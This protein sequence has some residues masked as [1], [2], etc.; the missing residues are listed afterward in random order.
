MPLPKDPLKLQLWRERQRISQT[1]RVQPESQIRKRQE[2]R[3]LNHPKILTPCANCGERT[4]HIPSRRKDHNYCSTRCQV[5]FEYETGTRDPYKITRKA[6]E[7]TRQL[8]KE[9]KHPLCSLENHIKARRELGRRHY[10]RT[11]LEERIGWALTQL[12]IEFEKQYPVKH[13]IDSLGRN[14]YYFVD[15]IVTGSNV[16]IEC[17]GKAWHKDE[18]KDNLRQS[19]IENLGWRFIRFSEDEI[20]ENVMGCAHKIKDLASSG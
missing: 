4:Y 14:R 3:L 16:A 11:W 10:G 6:N 13:G 12:G 20:N 18:A 17:D 2:T 9:G 7:V 8:V 15:F 1:G 19:Q 5:L